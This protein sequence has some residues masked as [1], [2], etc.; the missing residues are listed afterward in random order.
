MATTVGTPCGIAVQLILDGNFLTIFYVYKNE[1]QLIKF[2]F[3]F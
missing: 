2:F 3:F 1:I